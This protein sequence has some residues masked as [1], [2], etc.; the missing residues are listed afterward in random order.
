MSTIFNRL[1]K[2]LQDH[3]HEYNVDHRPMMNQVLNEMRWREVNNE[4][5]REAYYGDN[6][7]FIKDEITCDACG[8]G[9]SQCANF[10]YPSEM[11]MFREYS[12]CSGYC[13]WDLEYDIR[14]SCRRQSRW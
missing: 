6:Y 11:I 8:I 13:Q 12:F 3:V 14:K 5:L 9:I 2:E 4:L 10:E 1:P 7:P